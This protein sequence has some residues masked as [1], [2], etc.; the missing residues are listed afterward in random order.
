[1]LS[2]LA[3]K[4]RLAAAALLLSALPL[5]A[6]LS[7][8]E[9]QQYRV[10]VLLLRHLNNEARSFEAPP[11]TAVNE[12]GDA[13]SLEPPVE[14]KRVGWR[15]LPWAEL[16]LERE[17]SRLRRSRD[18]RA[19]LHLGWTQQALDNQRAG[20]VPVRGRAEDGTVISGYARLTVSRYLHLRLELEADIPEKG[21]FRLEESRRMKSGELHYF[22]H[23]EL[24]ALV[25]II[26]EPPPAE[27]EAESES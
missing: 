4:K 2:E 15:N 16:R 1:M 3:H 25:T 11:V 23:P 17:S 27:T 24:G 21:S 5:I 22:D 6:G 13:A 14:R 20:W 8:E 18:F 9:P 19:L 12:F 10:E 26:P 7:A